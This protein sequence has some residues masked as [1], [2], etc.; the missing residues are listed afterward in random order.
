MHFWFSSD[1]ISTKTDSRI[2]EI[3]ND[4]VTDG[5]ETENCDVPLNSS[6]NMVSLKHVVP[7]KVSTN[8]QS[9][10]Q[11]KAKRVY[12]TVDSHSSTDAVNA[13]KCK[14]VKCKRKP[15]LQR[16]SSK[17]L[18]RDQETAKSVFPIPTNNN[19]VSTVEAIKYIKKTSPVQ[20]NSSQKIP[21][22]YMKD[23]SQ[24]TSEEEVHSSQDPLEIPINATEPAPRKNGFVNKHLKAAIVN[25]E[26]NM[27]KTTPSQAEFI[28]SKLTEMLDA[29]VNDAL[30]GGKPA[31]T[32][33]KLIHVGDML[34]VS[35]SNE[36]SMKW[37]NEM[38]KTLEDPRRDMNINLKTIQTGETTK[39][40]NATLWIPGK[41]DPK[42]LVM[43][44]LTAQNTWVDVAEWI[45]HCNVTT[46]SRNGQLF[47]FGI[48]PEHAK[49]IAA[50]GGKLSYK[51][52]SLP[53]TL[54]KPHNEDTLRKK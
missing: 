26:S 31:P 28:E 44:R 47:V 4:I 33:S 13:K 37:L 41:P 29:A 5:A 15:V 30:H 54:S 6:Q 48:F 10:N 25:T 51:F 27:G 45:V 8:M 52:T 35:C 2:N 3:H 22:V 38:I 34:K 46:K 19:K 11:A 50:N 32:F 18:S 42:D 14:M 20:L 43:K 9:N 12:R 17:T 21:V 24:V 16:V 1:L 40:Q 49:T 7:I 36:Y 53:I 39:F 23:I